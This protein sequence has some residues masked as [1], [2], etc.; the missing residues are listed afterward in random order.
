[1]LTE[2]DALEHSGLIKP[3]RPNEMMDPAVTNG[4]LGNFDIGWLNARSRDVGVAKEAELLKEARELLEKMVKEDCKAAS[5]DDV[6]MSGG[7]G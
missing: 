5:E 3:D 4:G 2:V 1:M 6:T 7:N